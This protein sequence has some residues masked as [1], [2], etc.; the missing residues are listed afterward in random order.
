MQVCNIL[1]Y[2]RLTNTERC[3]DTYKTCMTKFAGNNIYRATCAD[4][5]ATE[6]LSS[7]IKIFGHTRKQLFHHTTKYW[8]CAIL[9]WNS[10]DRP[11]II[12]VWLKRSMNPIRW[13]KIGHSFLY[14]ASFQVCLVRS[15]S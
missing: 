13:V 4:C 6:S 5:R 2:C 15:T 14:V 8:L 3:R 11:L 12:I 1:R 9:K 10:Q 7:L